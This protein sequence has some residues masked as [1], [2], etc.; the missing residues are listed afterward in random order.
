MRKSFSFI[1][2]LLLAV[3]AVFADQGAL[4]NAIEQSTDWKTA[5]L[6]GKWKMVSADPVIVS[7]KETDPVF[8]FTPKRIIVFCRG[9]NVFE[10]EIIYMQSGYNAWQKPPVDK[11]AYAAAF[12]KMKSDLP[13]A[14][15]QLTGTTGQARTLTANAANFSFDV[16]DYPYSGLTLRLYIDG[17]KSI[18][19]FLAK[20][21]DSPANL[22]EMTSPEDRRAALAR[23]VVHNP[24]GD[25]VIAHLPCIDQDG[26]PDCGPA[27]WTEVARYYGLNVFQEMMMSERRDGGK[28]IDGAADLKKDWE[29]KFDFAKL[30]QSI[31]AG[32]PIWFEEHGHVALVTGYN[33]AQ[34]EVFRTDSWGEGARNKRVPVDRFVAKAL[35]FIYFVP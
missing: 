30:E 31:D 12:E 13:K 9:S 16:V 25:V 34:K 11:A 26:R 7:Q 28:G 32:S 18:C 6:P 24:N 14:L 35:G 33:A 27:C 8:G 15:A 2:V 3:H 22:L 10:A 1:V 20:P 21:E 17:D 5:P 29:T 19:V 23:N 4:V